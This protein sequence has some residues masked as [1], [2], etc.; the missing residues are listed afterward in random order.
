MIGRSETGA[1]RAYRAAPVSALG[2]FEA[3][4]SEG[5]SGKL[6][7]LTPRNRLDG[8]G[9]QIACPSADC[10]TSAHY[11][12]HSHWT[13]TKKGLPGRPNYGSVEEAH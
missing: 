7:L 9:S 13:T 4:Q 5:E 2:K 6:Y 11:E 12:E 1:A 3:Q 8:G 10:R